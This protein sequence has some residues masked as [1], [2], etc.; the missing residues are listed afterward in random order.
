MTES[1]VSEGG[2]SPKLLSSSKENLKLFVL[3]SPEQNSLQRMADALAN[4]TKDKI[5]ES[6]SAIDGILADLAFTLSD[7]RTAFQWRSTF[8]ASSAKELTS[9]LTQRVKSGRAGKPPKITFVFT[10][11]GAQWHAMGRELLAYDVFARTI[12]EADEY[13]KGLGADW[14][15]SRELTASAEDSRIN[16]AKFSQPLCAVVQ[17]ALVNLLSHW[18]VKASAVV[19]HSSGEIG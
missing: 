1:P 10:G 2:G 19:G 12:R 7:R 9:V 11:Q 15:V 6:P 3:S 5:M 4:Y 14:S 17:I 16:M 8:V 18:G 13:M